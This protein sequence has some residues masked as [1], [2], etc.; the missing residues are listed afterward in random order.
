[1][2]IEELK[3]KSQE[4]ADSQGFLLQPDEKILNMI[5]TGLLNNS[6]KHGEIYCPCRRVTG[7]KAEDK[8][9]ICPCIYHKDEIKEDGHC[10][11]LLFVKK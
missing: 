3:Q 1:M 11:C 5:L 2:N 4:Y 10:K 7:D 8:N 6:I 9:I